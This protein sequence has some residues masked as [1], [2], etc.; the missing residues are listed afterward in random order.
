MPRGLVVFLLALLVA[1]VAVVVYFAVAATSNTAASPSPSPV[2]TAAVPAAAD[3]NGG[4]A[5]PAA[6]EVYYRIGGADPQIVWQSGHNGRLV[7]TTG[8]D[9]YYAANGT[10]LSYGALGEAD[11]EARVANFT[12]IA[13]TADVGMLGGFMGR[14]TLVATRDLVVDTRSGESTA[15]LLGAHPL[16]YPSGD[17]P[18]GRANAVLGC[19]SGNVAAYTWDGAAWAMEEVVV[20][21]VVANFYKCRTSGR[22]LTVRDADSTD[23]MRVV[24]RTADGAW[25]PHANV[26]MA[27]VGL[28][29]YF[30][31]HAMAPDGLTLAVADD[32]NSS[33]SISVYTRAE[34]APEAAWAL[35]ATL[36]CAGTV[37][38]MHWYEDQLVVV[39]EDQELDVFTL[40]GGEFTHVLS[41]SPGTS[42]FRTFAAHTWPVCHGG[43]G[44]RHSVLIQYNSGGDT[45]DSMRVDFT[46]DNVAVTR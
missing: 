9:T 18:Y 1:G 16:T 17:S 31:D 7:L 4:V 6:P 45:G 44:G 15:A 33:N 36:Q 26:D 32:V 23:S 42:G 28:K 25:R 11:D 35:A 10:T 24:E 46:L 21:G 12:P 8:D 14:G 34:A 20:D 41:W 38:H 43:A 40:A 29:E 27:G 13:S 19:S 30:T 3:D 37:N 2:V 39:E 22:W 5:A